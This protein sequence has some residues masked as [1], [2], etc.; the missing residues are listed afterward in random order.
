MRQHGLVPGRRHARNRIFVSSRY[1]FSV[2]LRVS[3]RSHQLFGRLWLFILAQRLLID[4]QNGLA[5]IVCQ[6]VVRIVVQ[7]LFERGARRRRIVEIV[8]VDFRYRE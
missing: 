1:P 6:P 8:L 5:G 4:L 2:V 3:R 7:K